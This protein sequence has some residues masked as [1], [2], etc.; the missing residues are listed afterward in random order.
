MFEMII[1]KIDVPGQYYVV[2]CFHKPFGKA[3]KV[4]NIIK[5]SFKT[6]LN[7]QGGMSMARELTVENF[8]YY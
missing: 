5:P 7:E 3:S 4:A 1:K 2:Y 6:L 8:F